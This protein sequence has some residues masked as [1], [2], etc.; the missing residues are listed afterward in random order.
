MEQVKKAE[1]ASGE[2]LWQNI[3]EEGTFTGECPY[4][5]LFSFFNYGQEPNQFF[6]QFYIMH[7]HDDYKATTPKDLANPESEDQCLYPGGQLCFMQIDAPDLGHCQCV[8]R[9][10]DVEIE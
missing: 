2:Q 6:P 3:P 4:E 5:K 7:N 1:I 8:D 9:E 10:S